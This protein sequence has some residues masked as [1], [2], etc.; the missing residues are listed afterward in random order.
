MEY[1]KSNYAHDRKEIMR[2][3]RD[4]E[5]VEHLGSGIPRILE[6]YGK[7]VFE[8]RDSYIRI[9]FRKFESEPSQD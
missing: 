6:A 4:L 2:V 9:V 1:D 5:I 8:I 3:F 7:D